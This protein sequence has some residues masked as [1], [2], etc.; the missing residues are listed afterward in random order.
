MPL[1][2]CPFWQVTAKVPYFWD[3]NFLSPWTLWKQGT[4]QTW[5]LLLPLYTPLQ[6]FLCHAKSLSLEQHVW[7]ARCHALVSP[8]VFSVERI[9]GKHHK[10]ARQSVVGEL[11]GIRCPLG[12]VTFFNITYCKS[13]HVRVP[14]FLYKLFSLGLSIK[15]SAVMLI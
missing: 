15:L 9:S 6:A 12:E 8:E 3:F 13:L 10:A 7:M 4:T 1:L 5:E 11:K 14:S 2:C